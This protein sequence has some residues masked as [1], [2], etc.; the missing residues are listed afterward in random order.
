M[1]LIL[2]KIARKIMRQN[3]I[4]QFRDSQWENHHM[5]NLSRKYDR[6]TF[7]DTKFQSIKPTKVR[8][9]PMILSLQKI[10]LIEDVHFSTYHSTYSVFKCALTIQL[11]KQTRPPS[12]QKSKCIP[13]DLLLWSGTKPTKFHSI[14]T[15][16]NALNRHIS[17]WLTK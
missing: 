8:K 1:I 9:C 16:Y 6:A 15:S 10:I 5:L 3:I 14:L 2:Q 7:F 4:S 13:G 11:T 17:V 12:G